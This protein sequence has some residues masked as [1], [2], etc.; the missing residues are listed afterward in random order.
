MNFKKALGIILFLVF[1]SVFAQQIRIQSFN[2]PN[3][4]WNPTTKTLS[5]NRSNVSTFLTPIIMGRPTA[6]E[7]LGKA[8]DAEVE[9]T[10]HKNNSTATIIQ[11][12]KFV[13][14]DFIGNTGISV[15]RNHTINIP[16]G[17]IGEA[18]GY[19]TVK[20]RYN[21]QDYPWPDNN[22]NGWTNW[23]TLNFEV[24]FKLTSI[25]R[26]PTTFNRAIYDM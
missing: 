13:T 19:L 25:E 4:L 1:N 6:T 14:E 26:P 15:M 17:F 20:W 16:H 11:T 5:V 9:F 8:I 10:V 24:N 2:V 18:G 3:S 21:K 22:G 7:W 12:I 23:Y